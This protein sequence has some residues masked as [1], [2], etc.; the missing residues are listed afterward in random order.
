M[1]P[2]QEFTPEEMTMNNP[3]TWYATAEVPSN[4]SL[5]DLAAAR[6]KNRHELFGHLSRVMPINTPLMVTLSH[7][8]ADDVIAKTRL[9]ADALTAAPIQ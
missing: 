4:A 9:I 5:A 6:E 3:I 2:S 1:N 7:D 8:E